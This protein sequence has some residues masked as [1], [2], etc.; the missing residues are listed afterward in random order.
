MDVVR[1]A[2]C[3]A[4]LS[5]R[6]R[7]MRILG[8]VILGLIGLVGLPACGGQPNEEAASEVYPSVL[9]G[10]VLSGVEDVGS[11]D[12][13]A[14]TGATVP[15]GTPSTGD[16]RSNPKA[17]ATAAQAPAPSS[18]FRDSRPTPP[19]WILQMKNRLDTGA[20]GDAWPEESFALWVETWWEDALIGLDPTADFVG[21]SIEAPLDLKPTSWQNLPGSASLSIRE[22][23]DFEAPQ[24]LSAGTGLDA[25][26]AQLRF[27]LAPFDLPGPVGGIEW[28]SKVHVYRIKAR[29]EGRFEITIRM[30]VWQ[31]TADGGLSRTWESKQVWSGGPK[32]RLERFEPLLVQESR[33]TSAM[34]VDLTRHVL[35]AS[36]LPEASL[37]AGGV[38]LAGRHDQLLPASTQYLGM[39]GLAVG[40]VSG[41]GLEDLY[42]A[43]AGGFANHLFVAQPDGTLVDQALEAGVADLDDTGGVLI[44]DLDGDGDRDLIAGLGSR[45]VISWNDG[46]GHFKERSTLIQGPDASMVYSLCAADADGDGDLDLYD[47]RYFE[48]GRRGSAP[49][50]Y[51]DANN[52]APNSYWRNEGKRTFVEATK[53]VG[54]DQANQRFSLAALWEDLDGD[55]DLDLYVTNDFGRNN[56]YRNDGGQ[57]VDIAENSDALD[58]AASMGVSAADV[59]RDG[60]LDL[61][62]SNMY[63][64]AGERILRN[65]RFQQTA[66]P[67]V[68]ES[69]AGHAR[70]NTLLMGEGDGNFRFDENMAGTGPGGWSWGSVFV[71]FDMNGLPDIVVPNGFATGKVEQDLAS[72]FW[73]VVV[74]ASPVPGYVGDEYLQ[75]WQC[76][77]QLSVADGLSWNGHERHYAYW[78]LGA[79]RF[80]DIS[81]VSGLDLLEDGR[82]AAVVD[83]DLDGRPDLWL[84]H[85]TAPIVRFMHNRVQSPGHWISLELRGKAPNTEAVGALV[86]VQQGDTH[87]EAR[88]YAGEGYL[89]GGSKRRLFGLGEL[90]Q[91]VSVSIHWPDGEVQKLDPLAVDH[92][93]SVQQGS[94][95]E[96]W[97]P[98]VA[99]LAEVSIPA[100]PRG[101][102]QSLSRVIPVARLPL[103]A[104]DLPDFSKQRPTIG[105]L[106]PDPVLVF[107]YAA[108]QGGGS[109]VLEKLVEAQAKSSYSIRILNVDGPRQ[110][111]QVQQQLR[112]LNLLQNAGR[113]GRRVRNLIDTIL[114][115][116]LGAAEDRELPIGLLFDSEGA[117]AAIYLNDLPMEQL[118]RD[119]QA[120]RQEA[121]GLNKAGLAG[122]HWFAEAPSR[123]LLPLAAFLRRAGEARLAECMESWAASRATSPQAK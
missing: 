94:P 117:L 43:R 31:R 107:I 113:G 33:T 18:V 63:T 74:N 93:Y 6:L 44:C 27:A 60:N 62:I 64:A 96:L 118:E 21:E 85:R 97:E 102:G 25:W 1:T 8:C 35:A 10:P 79:G 39:H 80:M 87:S 29:P 82:C 70:G 72:F 86:Q 56:L 50:P 57:F 59:D 108:W 123:S 111:T 120:L 28:G 52:G 104:W 83:W 3:L 41:D 122:G 91:D 7:V 115:E 26:K 71:D 84:A 114:G 90:D 112:D 66:T 116:I 119:A 17:S 42:V 14:V 16:D 49:T 54:L 45:V 5:Y 65:P 98:Q 75:G 20:G 48:G 95:A 58:M 47:T 99:R 9:S 37:Y 109:E 81:A 67:Q 55:G 13:V 40:D 88:V 103:A 24:P 34:F 22:S 51:H 89:G 105:D 78:N 110:A 76:V 53:E 121:A 4:R 32:P 92:L 69:Y 36:V 11:T 30:R 2:Q 106:G 12:P 46:N 38:E 61:Y 68:R 101:T 100:A 23:R 15:A 77:T 73:R 19:A